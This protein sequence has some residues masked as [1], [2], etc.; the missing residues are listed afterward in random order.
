MVVGDRAD[1]RVVGHLRA[2]PQAQVI[3]AS[4]ECDRRLQVGVEEAAEVL[5]NWWCS[6]S[7]VCY[8]CPEDV[9]VLVDLMVA[10]KLQDGRHVG[11]HHNVCRRVVIW[12]LI[13]TMDGH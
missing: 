4:S 10:S 12:V 3:D 7:A 8:R 11:P 13:A 5:V 1:V 6:A 9:V 2:L